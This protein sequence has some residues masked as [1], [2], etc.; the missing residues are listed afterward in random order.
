MTPRARVI[1][2]VAVAAALAAGGVVGVTLLQTRGES[3][4]APGTV[5]TPRPGIPPL[6]FDFGVRDD[7]ESQALTRAAALLAHKQVAAARAIFARYRS[8]PAQIGTAFA[9]WPN[10]GLDTLKRLSAQNPGSALAAFELGWALYWSGRVGDA[11]TTWQQVDTKFPDSPES[12]EA[13]NLLYPKFARDL[14]FIVLPVAL[15]S[16]PTRAAQ[17]RELAA[18]ARRPDELAKLRYGLA[19]WQLWRRVSA[20]REFAAATRLAPND[21]AARTAA[22]VALFTK[23]A[24]VR[25]FAKLGPLTGVFPRSSAV[26]F[27]LGVLLVWTGQA[28]KGVAELRLAAADEPHS[29]YAREARRLLGALVTHGTK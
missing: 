1:A 4:T 24:P 26:R 9:N 23:R 16:A 18:A 27:H 14:P 19:L 3:T 6:F 5:A 25:A 15:P 17:L 13:E 8:L 10:G 22:A 2:I 21:P 11:V 29:L 12:V 28:K 7:P 20:E